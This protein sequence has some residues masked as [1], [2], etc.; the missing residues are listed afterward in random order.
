MNMTKEQYIWSVVTSEIFYLP[1]DSSGF[2]S[3]LCAI[4]SAITKSYF[5]NG[6]FIMKGVPKWSLFLHI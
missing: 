3:C 1:K 2:V 5:I 6:F 4:H